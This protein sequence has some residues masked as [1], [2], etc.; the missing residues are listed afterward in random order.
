[1]NRALRAA[2]MGVLVLSP[3]ALSACSAGQ[4]TQTASQERDKTGAQAQV[5]DI[6]LREGR[7][8]YPRGGVYE[9]GDDAE[10]ELAIVNSGQQSDTLTDVEGDGFSSADI[11]DDEIEI[12]TDS[13][14]FVGEGDIT[15]TLTDLDEGITTGQILK[16][17][18][19]F[20]DAG[21]ITIP[22]TVSNPDRALERGESFDFQQ[23]D[24]N[25][26]EVAREDE[27]A[28]GN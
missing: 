4:V 26:G 21:D 10:L 22:V 28:N 1:V 11:S 25:S 20:Q 5:G 12:P 14:V 15:I 2:T 23:G 17:T 16:V 6:T 18:L 7:L 19:T 24:E 9:A 13:T 8:A 27:S 3:L